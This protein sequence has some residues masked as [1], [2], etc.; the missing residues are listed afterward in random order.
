M[1]KLQYLLLVFLL[2]GFQQV[3]GQASLWV[4]NPQNN[5]YW[6]TGKIEKATLSVRPAGTYFEMGLY[7]TVSS[8]G[9]GFS[10]DVQLEAL[11]N[12]NL[13]EGSHVLD[14]WLWVYEDI[15]QGKI[16]DK[17]T[18]S[19]IYEGIVNRRR[20]P[21]LLVKNG[22][23]QYELRVY[24][25]KP[26]EQR[27]IKI[28]YLV[29]AVWSN[30]KATVPL[31][32]DILRSSN[33]VPTLHTLVWTSD[34]WSG[35]D[36]PEL[37]DEQFT[38]LYDQEFGNYYRYDIP[39]TQVKGSLSFQLNAP[40]TNGM[41]LTMSNEDDGTGMYQLAMDFGQF[42][43]REESVKLAILIDYE[44]ANSTISREQVFSAL[45]QYLAANYSAQDS[46]N[47]FYSRYQI[48]AFSDNWMPITEQNLEAAF[49]PL[50]EGFLTLYSNLPGL[51]A[52]GNTF[53][54]DNGGGNILLYTDA[55]NYGGQEKANQ[56]LKDIKSMESAP[57]H[58]ADFQNQHRTSQYIGNRWYYGQEYFFINLS[59]ITGGQY[60]VLSSN[61]SLYNLCSDVFGSLG[62]TITAFDLYSSAN[63]GFCYARY[64]QSD[65]E[66]YH[67]GDFFVQTGKFIGGPP[68]TINLTGIF[69][70][71]PFNQIVQVESDQI[72]TGDSLVNKAWYGLHIRDMER[73]QEDNEL[74]NKVLFESL[75]QRVLSKYSAF[76][77]LEPS[78]TIAV[79]V[80]CQDES[81]LTGMDELLNT[82]DESLQ[83]YPNPCSE[84]VKLSF[85]SGDSWNDQET[86]I[87]IVSVTGE[88]VFSAAPSFAPGTLVELE[89]NLAGPSGAKVAKGYYMVLVT[90]GEDRLR[91]ALIIN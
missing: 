91:K 85:M 21:S 54:E 45:E 42:L 61:S 48:E 20:D 4:L 39:D 56:L 16:I 17:W 30:G 18:A 64:N 37:S 68:F 52:K 33:S 88:V 2:I 44:P 74:I 71:Q 13:P 80:D 89:W 62:G 38:P 8:S 58:I 47:L 9:S 40:L 57:V 77:C 26:G 22:Q 25:M 11:L 50:K 51:I 3:I 86:R 66:T 5:W 87:R 46:F 59:R 60:Q 43:E 83:I 41:F 10:G 32:T 55:D 28:T 73:D 6:R 15:V 7:L 69:N 82:E 78:D 75:D 24:P 53:L 49:Q 72:L 90:H 27:K 34:G 12:F 1:K 67:L 36:I 31:P 84:Y 70:Q 14:S 23:D 81:E 29:P 76:L 35:P 65:S 63:G 79:C 19:N